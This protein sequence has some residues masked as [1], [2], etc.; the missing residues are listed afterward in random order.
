MDGTRTFVREDVMLVASR[1]LISICGKCWLCVS[2]SIDLRV[3]LPRWK[4]ERVLFLA[5][6]RNVIITSQNIYASNDSDISEFSWGSYISVTVVLCKESQW[7]KLIWPDCT[8]GASALMQACRYLLLG[9]VVCFSPIV[10]EYASTL[11][12]FYNSLGKILHWQLTIPAT[13]PSAVQY[14]WVYINSLPL[15]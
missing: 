4:E 9:D 12:G 8:E 6:R 3:P 5:R 1:S 14:I 15:N 13:I 10:T 11:V 2:V 7:S